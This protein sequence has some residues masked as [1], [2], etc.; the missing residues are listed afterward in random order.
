MTSSA[1]VASNP[2]DDGDGQHAADRSVSMW[3]WTEDPSLPE[4]VGVTDS[5]Y[6]GDLME[7]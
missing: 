4:I 5:R 3:R 1:R 7:F 2:N 6:R